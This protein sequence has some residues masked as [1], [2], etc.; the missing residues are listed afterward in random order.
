MRDVRVFSGGCVS[1]RKHSFFLSL[2]AKEKQKCFFFFNS[3]F[4]YIVTSFFKVTPSFIFCTGKRERS[5]EKTRRLHLRGYSE[6]SR[7][8]AEKTRFAQTG[9]CFFTPSFPLCASR[10][11]VRPDPYLSYQLFFSNELQVASSLFWRYKRYNHYSV[12]LHT[13]SSCVVVCVGVILL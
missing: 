11:S 6:G 10:P 13:F 2:F 5:K 3:F 9:F 8:K 12:Y 1:A 4:S 7:A